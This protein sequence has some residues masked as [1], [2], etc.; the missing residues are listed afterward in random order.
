MSE[1]IS[2]SPW[3]GVC[4]GSET[5]SP[6]MRPALVDPEHCD[7]KSKETTVGEEHRDRETDNECFDVPHRPH[8]KWRLASRQAGVQSLTTLGSYLNINIQLIAIYHRSS[9]A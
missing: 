2:Q 3:V 5:H 1:F 4:P 9:P 6:K 7:E 8:Q